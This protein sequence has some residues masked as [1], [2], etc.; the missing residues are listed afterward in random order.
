[1]LIGL[2]IIVAIALLLT[3]IGFV[4]MRRRQPA[5][6]ERKVDR[7]QTVNIPRHNETGTDWR[8]RP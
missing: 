3:G 5:V 6:P 2:A 7:G 1:M 8:Y 4:M